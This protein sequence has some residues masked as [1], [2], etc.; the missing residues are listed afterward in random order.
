MN[1]QEFLAHISV[2]LAPHGLEYLT[3]WPVQ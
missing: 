2:G 3:F 1:E